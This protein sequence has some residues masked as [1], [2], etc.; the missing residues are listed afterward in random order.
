MGTSAIDATAKGATSNSYAT[1]A[2]ADQYHDNRVASGTTWGGS[3][4]NE[5]IRA[6]L[7]AT[8]LMESLWDWNGAVTNTTQVLAWPRSGLWDRNNNA[9]DEDTLPQ[10]VIDAQ[11]E[12]ARQLLVSRR[13]D[14]NPTEQESL[15]E[16]KAGPITLKFSE[17]G[18]YNKI[19]PD[20]VFHLIP[21]DWGTP[22][23]RKMS[24]LGAVR[25]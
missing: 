20:A 21:E 18:T 8:E 14:D 17:S 10:P 9:L 7:W 23:G 2:Q 12:F 16:L 3:S 4:E 15:E 6:L 24:T 13:A 22:R 11:S 1:L 25:A 5:K 19:V